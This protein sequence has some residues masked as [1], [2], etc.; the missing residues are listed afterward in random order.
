MRMTGSKKYSPVGTKA[1]PVWGS[2]FDQRNS[3][4]HHFTIGFQKLEICAHIDTSPARAMFLPE[5]F[6][7]TVTQI[8]LAD[9]RH[10]SEEEEVL[11]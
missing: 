11:V 2:I 4:L 6:T 5:P 10:P 3:L 8:V 9:V 1:Q 7:Y